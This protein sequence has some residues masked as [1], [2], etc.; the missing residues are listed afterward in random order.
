[1]RTGIGENSTLHETSNKVR[2]MAK[3]VVLPH[4]HGAAT[5]IAIIIGVIVGVI[6]AHL[7]FALYRV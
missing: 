6:L 7:L 1:M 5:I 4:V 3:P 2:K